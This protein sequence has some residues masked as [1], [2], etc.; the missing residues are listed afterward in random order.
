MPTLPSVDPD[1]V[2]RF[3]D[4]IGDDA[5]PVETCPAP[6]ATKE[7]VKN[8]PTVISAIGHLEVRAN[9]GPVAA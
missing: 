5:L 8:D 2:D 4:G 6:V 1:F 3:G 7:S 9:G